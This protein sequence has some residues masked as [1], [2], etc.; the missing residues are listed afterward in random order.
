MMGAR[1]PRA[2]RAVCPAVGPFPWACTARVPRGRSL[3][4]RG[5]RG[6]APSRRLL[7]DLAYGPLGASKGG[8]LRGRG[9]ISVVARLHTAHAVAQRREGRQ[10]LNNDVWV[11]VAKV[12][13]FFFERR[14]LAV[15]AR[16][17]TTD[18]WPGPCAG[19]K[20]RHG[21]VAQWSRRA[22]AGLPATT[23]TFAQHVHH[24]AGG[25]GVGRWVAAAT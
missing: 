24:R 5:L 3:A 23:R 21:N 15:R 18:L 6:H 9:P 11:L 1:R 8:L 2:A 14:G 13:C 16:T 22:R 7:V 25:S 19:V 10:S 12:T 4:A 17:A 20:T